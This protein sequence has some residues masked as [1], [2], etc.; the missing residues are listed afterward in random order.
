[1]EP[2][3]YETTAV[4]T[5]SLAKALKL[6]NRLAGRLAQINNELQQ[7]NSVLQEQVTLPGFKN[8]SK[9][10]ELRRALVQSILDVK[11]ALYKANAGIQPSLNEMA[12]LKSEISF[13]NSLP[14]TEGTYKHGYQNT[15]NVYVC[16]LSKEEINLRIRELEARIDRLQDEVDA[17]NVTSKITVSQIV[18]DVA[19]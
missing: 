13:L 12:E 7:S 5:I 8:F 11:N 18:L 2:S 3:K 4:A 14:T 17:Y 15:D 1:M 6:K 16:N 19:S 10:L 9:N